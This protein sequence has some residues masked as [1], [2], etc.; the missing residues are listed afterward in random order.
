[1]AEKNHDHLADMLSAMAN[2][3]RLP[4]E[5]SPEVGEETPPAP[6]PAPTKLRPATPKMPG[7]VRPAVP[8]AELQAAA[9]GPM[10][11]PIASRT[12]APT[13][14]APMQS[15]RKVPRRPPP[16]ATL[17]FK[18]TL[19]PIQ[20]MLAACTAFTGSLHWLMP[21]SFFSD[22]PA[23]FSYL[24]FAFSL[25]FLCGAVAMMMTV[26]HHLQMMRQRK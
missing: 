6:P 12:G 18:Q 25:P 22:A 10:D 3:Q 17:D 21:D 1:M 11:H 13:A 14:A 26:H 5:A 7:P 16:A 23:W 8:P 15:L 24:M 20:L 19:I 9:L 4:K 2:G